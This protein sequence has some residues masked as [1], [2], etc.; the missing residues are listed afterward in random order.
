MALFNFGKKKEEEKGKKKR[1][2][3]IKEQRAGCRHCTD[4]IG[5]DS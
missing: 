4:E 5:R 1:N 3:F 2:V